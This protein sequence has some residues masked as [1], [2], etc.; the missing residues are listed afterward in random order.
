MIKE[1][2]LYTIICDNCGKDCNKDTEYCAYNDSQYAEDVA[3]DSDWYKTE[4]GKHICNDC[5]QGF[6]DD[7]NVIIKQINKESETGTKL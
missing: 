2:T 1:V 3:I 4:D 5:F 6:D 7:D